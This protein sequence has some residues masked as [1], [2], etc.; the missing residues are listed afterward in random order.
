MIEPKVKRASATQEEIQARQS[1]GTDEH[2][3][4][5]T[6]DDGGQDE[7]Q[8]ERF[9]RSARR[10]RKPLPVRREYMIPLVDGRT[11]YVTEQKLATLGQ[12]YQVAAREVAPGTIAQKHRQPHPNA[13]RAPATPDVLY[14]EPTPRNTQQPPVVSPPTVGERIRGSG[15]KVVLVLG[16]CF[17]V[18]VVGSVLFNLLGRWWQIQQDDWQY[19]RPRTYQVDAN[20]GHGTT[21]SPNSH[22]IAMNLNRRIE[23][24]EVQGD[25]PAHTKLYVGPSLIG[26][27]EELAPVT[28]SFEDVNHDGRLDMVLHVGDST[29]VFL[30]T[31]TD[32]KPAPN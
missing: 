20:V 2:S 3:T 29:F 9:P 23:V 1:R 17:I 28:L 32:F 22:F 15:G 19:G 21:A 25:D 14:G 16:I 27:G 8:P 31:G 11:L 13:N 18:I 12:D 4:S 5:Y 26:T 6:E 30:N 7:V 10:Y 24:I